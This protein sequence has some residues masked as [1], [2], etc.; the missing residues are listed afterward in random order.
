MKPPK[1]KPTGIKITIKPMSKAEVDKARGFAE[2]KGVKAP[3]PFK[4]KR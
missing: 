1:G 2:T 4:A 3:K